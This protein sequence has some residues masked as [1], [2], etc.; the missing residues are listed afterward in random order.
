LSFSTDLFGSALIV[1]LRP[2]PGKIVRASSLIS[3]KSRTHQGGTLR[4]TY[5]PISHTAPRQGERAKLIPA[6]VVNH[7]GLTGEKSYIYTTYACED[8]WPFD[9][10]NVPGYKGRFYY[11]FIPPKFFDAV[12]GSL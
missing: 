1:D 6:P 5:L 12:G 11:G 10:A 8:D 4:V 9:L 3:W 7:L 2:M